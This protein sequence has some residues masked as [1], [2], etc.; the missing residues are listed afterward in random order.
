MPGASKKLV[1][2]SVLAAVAMHVV[3][4]GLVQFADYVS[5]IFVVVELFAHG[6]EFRGKIALGFM[7]ASVALVFLIPIVINL[8]NT[9]FEHYYY[10]DVSWPREKKFYITVMVLAPINLHTLYLGYESA[11]IKSQLAVKEAEPMSRPDLWRRYRVALEHFDHLY[12]R[13][14]VRLARGMSK[15]EFEEIV[16]ELKSLREKAAAA[17]EE[18]QAE[19]PDDA[20]HFEM[21]D[22]QKTLYLLFV[23]SKAIETGVESVPLAILTTSMLFR[24]EAQVGGI[25]GASN[26][27]N[28]T[29]SNSTT[30]AAISSGSS[31]NSGL[32]VSSLILSMFSMTY[33]LFGGVM[34]A[35]KRSEPNLT[36]GR[37]GKIFIAIA[38]QVSYTLVATGMYFGTTGAWLLPLLN[39]MVLPC[40]CAFF[41]VF[42]LVLFCGEVISKARRGCQER[43]DFEAAKLGCR[44]LLVFFP[45]SI[46]VS[47]AVFAIDSGL[48]LTNHAQD[49]KDII[50][51]ILTLIRRVLLVWM[52]IAAVAGH[53]TVLRVVGGT[54]LFAI[55][56]AASIYLFRALQVFGYSPGA[57]ARVAPSADGQGTG[58]PSD[59]EMLVREGEGGAG[60]LQGE[61]RLQARDMLGEIIKQADDV[62]GADDTMIDVASAQ[63]QAGM[64]AGS[65][66]PGPTDCKLS[67]LQAAMSGLKEAADSALQ[68]LGSLAEAEVEVL[69]AA[70]REYLP[71][72]DGEAAIALREALSAMPRV[73]H[74]TESYGKGPARNEEEHDDEP[75][76]DTQDEGGTSGYVHPMRAALLRFGL[77]TSVWTVTPSFFGAVAKGTQYEWSHDAQQC[78]YFVSHAWKDDGKRKVEMLREFLFTQ[79]FVGRAVVT[80]LAIALFF[81]PLGFAIESQLAAWPWWLL[82]CVPL[83]LLAALL[84]WLGASLLGLVAPNLVPWALSVETIWIDKL[85]INQESN[86]TKAAGVA[87]F[88]RFLGQCDRMVAFIS[89]DY[90]TR[91]WCVYELATFTRMHEMHEDDAPSDKLLL[92]SLDWPSS[93]SPFKQ[94][95]VSDEEQQ[96]LAGFSC[97]NARCFN[98][99]P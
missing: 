69:V 76:H 38:I 79:A 45:F 16:E 4:V 89:R 65:E 68:S 75:S 77:M 57:S 88:S 87:G 41:A 22:R 27:T 74:D 5:D 83:A 54:C 39:M 50:Y 14:A 30:A 70:C 26:S 40:F 55:E 62:L 11:K 7:V 20:A 53:F 81:V 13:L 10:L 60:T 3:P 8:M 48:F 23:V 78:G 61:G 43:I 92:L 47:L 58:G 71:S 24:P 94:A 99:A 28:T 80:L 56:L 36:K 37:E 2:L 21:L 84:V 72:D 33:G 25:A 19:S 67:K 15:D 46:L 63:G 73:A 93:F 51:P 35:H 29:W 34:E 6:E 12:E 18:I 86:E 9:W 66:G 98:P 1:Y 64:G 32:L 59:Q 85:C 95:M 44:W 97:R 17:K 42:F 52:L 82:P 31:Y 91:L 96:W 49:I 90:F